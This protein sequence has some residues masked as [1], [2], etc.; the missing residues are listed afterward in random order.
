MTKAKQRTAS[1][2]SK[3]QSSGGKKDYVSIAI[4]YAEGAIEDRKREHHNAWIRAAARR[5]IDDIKRAQKP[6]APFLWVPRKANHACAFIEELRHVEGRWGTPTLTL[7]PSQ[8]F[9]I[10]NLFG[11]RNED[12]SRRFTTALY[13]VARKNAKSTLAAAIQ[14]YC[15]VEEDEIGPQVISAATT[16]SQARIVWNIAKRMI[17]ADSELREYYDLEPLAYNIVCW[18][19]GGTY[20]AINAKA[21]TQDGLNPSCLSFDEL[22]AHK[23]HDL[24]NV[25]R[26]AAGAR[27]NPLFLYTT[28]EGTEN[29]G[30]WRE[31][32][33]FAEQVLKKV[34]VAEHFLAILYGLDDEDDDFDETKWIKANPLLGVSVKLSKLQEYAAEAKSQPGSLSE[35][36]IKR[37][38]RR[39]SASKAWLHDLVKWNAG[40]KPVDL[41]SLVG[42]PCWGAFDLASTRDMTAWRLLWLK[43]GIY[44]TWGRYWVPERAVA[45]RR[46]T[47]TV[48]YGPWIDSGYIQQTPGDV[49]DYEVVEGLIIGDCERFKPQKVGYDA[50]N[51]ASTANNLMKKNLPLEQFIQGTR[52]YSP[53]MKA[54]EVAY[55]NGKLVH[56]DNPVLTWNMANVVPRVDVNLNTA[57]DRQRSTDK[58]DGACALFMCFGLAMSEAEKAPKKFQMI[59][60]GA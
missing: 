55:L 41:D 13:S 14:I 9:F 49:I 20:K 34:V 28:T 30:P 6:R 50:W 37:L 22:H 17:E 48:M 38:N 31:V 32:R 27:S 24:Y 7:E 53:S 47:G 33:A 60:L 19:N 54:C 8:I 51:A 4:A 56:G 15:Y 25:L 42:A 36:R 35:F 57:P 3:T 52:S 59:S 23:N 58:I 44:Y 29:P 46:S 11:F 43:D 10:C 39:A 45:Q 2:T 1:A 18:K 26:S 12:G 16:G 40:G 21:S 5:F